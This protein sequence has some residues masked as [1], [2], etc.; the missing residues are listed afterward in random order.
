VG[1]TYDASVLEFDFVPDRDEATF[2][3]VFGSNEY[4]EDDPYDDGAAFWVNGKNY[5]VVPGSTP[6]NQPVSVYRINATTN[7]ALFVDNATGSRDTALSGFTTV[8]TFTAP[9]VKGQVNHL[10]IAVTDTDDRIIDSAILLAPA[11]F[12]NEAPVAHNVSG[13]SVQSGK[14]VAI[15]LKGTDPDGDA[16]TYHLDQ[17]PATTAGK[18]TIDPDTGVAIFTAASGFTG[19]AT[20]T[21]IVSDGLADS[22]PA[23][24]TIRVV[25]APASPS[26]SP[27]TPTAS[28]S[29]LADTGSHGGDAAP[30][31]AGLA[32]AGIALTAG[33]GLRRRR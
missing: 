10:R 6:A 9:L 24:V 15:P 2:S 22:D 30:L 13:V 5:A 19:T 7:A 14:S 11:E 28:A 4:V 29:T 20:F 8:M 26:A 31:G 23:T 1:Q 33:V 16:L 25:A 17:A 21:Y 12:P 27:S 32:L 18:V 3:Y